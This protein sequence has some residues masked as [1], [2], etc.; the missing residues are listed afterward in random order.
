MILLLCMA[1]L[2]TF[3][4]Y[5]IKFLSLTLC[6]VCFLFLLFD[7]L[8]SS[9]CPVSFLNKTLSPIDISMS[10]ISRIVIKF[11]VFP[12]SFLYHNSSS[13]MCYF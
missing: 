11:F 10:F 5:K 8:E 12:L 3:V 4:N 1:I 7:V 13:F 9:L 6:T 2:E